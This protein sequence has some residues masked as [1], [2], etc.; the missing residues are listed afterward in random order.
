MGVD[1][2]S[3]ITDYEERVLQG[4]F[5]NVDDVGKITVAK[6]F[7]SMKT[8]TPKECPKCGRPYKESNCAQCSNPHGCAYCHL[9][10]HVVK[11]NG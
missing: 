7:I 5:G 6:R 11:R 1:R 3:D 4:Y 2:P 8:T 10:L 9:Q